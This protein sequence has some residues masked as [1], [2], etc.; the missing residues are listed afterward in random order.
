MHDFVSI[1]A[2]TLCQLYVNFNAN[3]TLLNLGV[4]K[5][6]RWMEVLS[7]SSEI[8]GGHRGG[9]ESIQSMNDKQQLG[10]LPAF[11]IC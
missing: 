1:D 5:A 3:T 9:W 8:L 2:V 7:G 11:S 4:C 6:L 10:K